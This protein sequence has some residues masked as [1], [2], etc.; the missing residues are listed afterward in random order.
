LNKNL[1]ETLDH[2]RQIIEDRRIDYNE[3]RPHGSLNDLTPKEF[4]EQYN[5]KLGKPMART[6][7][8]IS[9]DS[10]QQRP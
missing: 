9:G 1:I 5:A 10:T 4:F 7:T 2:A 8:T 6:T 3:E